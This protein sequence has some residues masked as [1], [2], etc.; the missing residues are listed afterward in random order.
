MSETVW[1]RSKDGDHYLLD[2]YE[3]HYSCYHYRDGRRRTQCVGPGEC[4][5]LRTWDAD[6]FFVWR[7]F[8]DDSGQ[9]G[10]NNAI[11]IN[12]R[13]DRYLSS[14]L[15]RSA[16]AVADIAWPNQRRYTY[17]DASKVKSTNPGFCY[18]KAGWQRCGVTPRGLIIFEKLPGENQ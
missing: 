7:K 5:V 2:A 16:C 12:Q 18:I 4:F 10:V 11:F 13:P 15:I 17:V 3:K 14:E 8:I 6:A 9:I 1:Y